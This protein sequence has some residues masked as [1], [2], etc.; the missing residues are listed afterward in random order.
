MG[1]AVDTTSVEKGTLLFVKRHLAQGPSTID[2]AYAD[3]KMTGLIKTG[4]KD[5]PVNVELGGPLFGE[6]AGGF[7]VLATLPLEQGYKTAFRNFDLQ[8]SKEKPMQLEVTGSEKVTVPAGDFEAWKVL[9]TPSDGSAGKATLWVAKAN[10]QMVKV[11]GVMAEMGGAILT[12][13]LQ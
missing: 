8:K 3:R 6:G 2:L 13:E 12:M 9:V 4:G 10:H 1:S 7:Q 5:L 11:V